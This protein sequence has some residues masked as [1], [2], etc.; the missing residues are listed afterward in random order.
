MHLRIG[1]KEG[2]ANFIRGYKAISILSVLVGESGWW[3][4]AD[5]QAGIPG[6]I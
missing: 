3:D 5:R 1:R 4:L 2:P 6:S